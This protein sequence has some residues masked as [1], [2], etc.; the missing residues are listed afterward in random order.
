MCKKRPCKCSCDLVRVTPGAEG[1]YAAVMHA[2][3]GAFCFTSAND[4]TQRY[5][6]LVIQLPC[7]GGDYHTLPV[8]CE[9]EPKPAGRAAWKWDGNE[10][11]PH[12]EPSI[13]SRRLR[14]DLTRDE[15]PP[16]GHLDADL[17][18]VWHG[19]ITGGRAESCP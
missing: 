8:Y 14:R 17:E 18:E 6:Q 3:P 11:Q 1:A 19:H 4:G 9:G 16:L 5:R 10:E 7:E 13:A 12:L 15:D 2:P